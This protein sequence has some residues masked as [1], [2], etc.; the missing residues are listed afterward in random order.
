M[1]RL[2]LHL[3]NVSFVIVCFLQPVCAIIL[4]PYT[5]TILIIM[6]LQVPFENVKVTF[7]DRDSLKE[8]GKA[9]LGA[10]PTMEVD[11]K[12]VCQT[13]AIARYC[14]KLGGFYP[15]DDDFTAAKI[16]EIID[17]ATDITMALGNT[18]KMGDEEKKAARAVLSTETLPKYFAALEKMM[19]ENGSTGQ[20]FF[21]V[22]LRPLMIGFSRVLCRQEHDDR[23]P[24]H[25][26][27]AGLGVGRRP[28][29]DPP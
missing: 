4:R 20:F 18:F 2:A 11:G 28:G 10:F 23:R 6:V 7:A 25:V 29:R 16:D 15:K 3:G 19:S 12:V 24:G 5:F 22:A 13:G 8:A 14:G 26:A 17:T 21:R 9:P 27:A 1:S